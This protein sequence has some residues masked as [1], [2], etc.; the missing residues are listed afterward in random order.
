MTNEIFI[1][2][3]EILNLDEL[4]NI[5]G[6][7]INETSKDSQ[8]LFNLGLIKEKFDNFETVHFW[9]KI[10]NAV[11]QGWAKVGISCFTKPFGENSY[12]IGNKQLTRDEAIQMAQ[13]ILGAKQ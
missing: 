13:K 5:S 10:S 3:T 9:N 8:D 7:T 12:S 6:G 4:D 1:N 2:N 11:D